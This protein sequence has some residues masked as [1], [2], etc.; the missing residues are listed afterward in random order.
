[1]CSLS[2]V[3]TIPLYICTTTSYP[4]IC[5]WISRLFLCPEKW[6]WSESEGHSVVSNSLRPHG[7]YSPGNSPGQNTGV[8]SLSLLLGI[9]PTQ[10]SN[11]GLQHCRW[12]LY[13]LSHKGSLLAIVNS[14]AV[15][16]G[17]HVSFSIMVFSGC[18]S[19]RGIVGWYGTII[20]GFIRNL[21]SG[22]INLQLKGWVLIPSLELPWWFSW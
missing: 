17:V 10:G 6:K 3:N 9:F 7:L 18:M 21:H 22:C 12:I 4:F 2:W 15:N 16:I 8:G 5:W 13:Q 19:S 14:A 20:P 11:P 1:M